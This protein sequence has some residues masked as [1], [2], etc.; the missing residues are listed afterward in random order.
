MLKELT[1][2]ASVNNLIAPT[3]NKTRYSKK[4]LVTSTSTTKSLRSLAAI[5]KSKFKTTTLRAL[6]FSAVSF[7]SQVCLLIMETRRS[8]ILESW[9]HKEKARVSRYKRKDSVI[10]TP[11]KLQPQC[12]HKKPQE[13]NTD[14]WSEK[15]K[16]LNESSRPIANIILKNCIKFLRIK[17]VNYS[18]KSSLLKFV[19][20]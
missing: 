14:E 17:F 18:Y 13:E 7:S 9:K 19:F 3:E 12:F 16:P 6:S 4:D 10:G 11:C 2:S 15:K 1:L 8:S 5:A 20:Y